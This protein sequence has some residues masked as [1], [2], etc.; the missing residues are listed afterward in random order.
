MTKEAKMQ[1]KVVVNKETGEIIGVF[2]TLKSGSAYQTAVLN[3]MQPGFTDKFY[4]VDENLW[5][6]VTLNK[7]YTPVVA[8][9]EKKKLKSKQNTIPLAETDDVMY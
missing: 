3:P 7:I 9:E 1:V 2:D 4:V 5:N 8:L 6:V